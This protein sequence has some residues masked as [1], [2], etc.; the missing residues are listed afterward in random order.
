M[1]AGGA[2]VALRARTPRSVRRQSHPALPSPGQGWGSLG[3]SGPLRGEP[4]GHCVCAGTSPVGSQPAAPQQRCGSKTRCCSCCP[5]CF[6]VQDAVL[7]GQNQPLPPG[8]CLISRAA[9]APRRASRDRG[10]PGRAGGLSLARTDRAN[11]PSLLRGP[12]RRSAA[13]RS[14]PAQ[15]DRSHRRAGCCLSGHPRPA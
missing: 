9:P 14:F 5:A 8:G 2:A 4:G 12:G 6:K 10:A 1:T 3:V 15:R 11:R 13:P 7:A